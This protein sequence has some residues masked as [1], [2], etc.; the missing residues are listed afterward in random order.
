MPFYA[1]PFYSIDSVGVSFHSGGPNSPRSFCSYHIRIY[2]SSRVSSS[3][4]LED[5]EAAFLPSSPPLLS[6]DFMPP[7]DDGGEDD[8]G[9]DGED[10]GEDDE[11]MDGTPMDEE[12]GVMGDDDAMMS[13]M[14][15]RD[16]YFDREG[17]SADDSD[18]GR[19]NDVCVID[20]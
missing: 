3:L 8:G 6:D 11:E 1:I 20:R 2:L 17:R 5:A 19:D 16:P 10:D 13:T 7:Y 15:L 4:E 14:M 18:H 9:D 12:D